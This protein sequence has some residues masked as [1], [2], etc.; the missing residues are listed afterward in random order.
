[1]TRNNLNFTRYDD[2]RKEKLLRR[3]REA[4]RTL[5]LL[6]AFFAVAIGV[7]V[8]STLKHYGLI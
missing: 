2:E 8:A 6:W 4:Q 1:M 7:L 5:F 3:K